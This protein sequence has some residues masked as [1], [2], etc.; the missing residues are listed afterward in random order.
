[1]IYLAKKITG[2]S[3][4]VG[5][6]LVPK[7]LSS[8]IRVIAVD[9]FWFGDY[10]PD[11]KSLSKIN[12]DIRDLR[13]S[14]LPNLDSIIHLAA[15]ANDPSVDLDPTLS[16]EIGCLG[17]R[18]LCEI[19]L[20]KEIDLFVLASSGSVYGIKNE[21]KVTENLEL[22]PISVYNKVKMVK[23]RI[24]LSYKESFRTVI[25]RPA[26]IC[27][28]SPRMRLDLA[29]NALT[30]SALTKG[31][32]TVF[33][34]E[35]LRP[36][37]HIDDMIRAYE[38]ALSNPS[39]VGLYNIGFEN[40]SILDIAKKVQGVIDSKIQITPSNDL[41]SYRLDS[42]RILQTGFTPLKKSIDAITEIKEH[43]ESGQL[44]VGESNFN[45]TWMSKLIS[46]GSIR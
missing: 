42:S 37:L 18:N 22:V 40:D 17:T 27:G 26:T 15:V 34:G 19:G 33:G 2:A 21:P 28:N 41:R 10:L 11:H 30:I 39:I 16:W 29:V 5:S 7:L 25:Y 13:A 24:A 12:S 14:D 20:V 4:Y 43:F 6:S 31:E 38:W 44:Q 35:Q 46:N 3:G 23:E 36:Q 1:V 32:I 45:V 9:T 8:G